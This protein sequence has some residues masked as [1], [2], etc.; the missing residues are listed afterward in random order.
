M[1]D[2]SAQKFAETAEAK[3]AAIVE[4]S[5]D[6][7]IGKDLEGTVTSWNG[8]A[9]KIFGYTAG[10]MVGASILR[11]IPPDRA[12]E[13]ERLMRRLKKGE[14]I[15]HFET[16]R[17]AKDGRLLDV[18]VAISPIIHAN[19]EIVG[20]SKVA[21]DITE[22][23]RAEADR[24]VLSKLESTGILAGGIAHDF[25]NL[26]TTILL[27]LELVLA[28]HLTADETKECLEMAMQSVMTS[29]GLTEQLITFADG[30]APNQQV[31]ALPGLIGKTVRLA[32]SGTRTESE[33]NLPGDLWSAD[34]DPGQ[35]GQVIQNL[36]LNAREAMS[37]A[38]VVSIRAEN[39]GGKSGAEHSLPPGNYIRLFITD[40]GAGIPKEILPTIFDPYVSTKQRGNR[41]GMGLGLTICHSIIQRHGGAITVE[42][43][44]GRG[45]TFKIHLPASSRPAPHNKKSPPKDP[46]R[47]GRLL[48]MDDD[49]GVRL[50]V[51]A[52]LRS[53]CHKVEMCADGAQAVTA[54]ENARALKQPF[55]AVI[56]DLTVRGG[57]GGL[58]ALQTLRGI[59]PAV[60]AIVISGHANDP[61]MLN[62]EQHGFKAALT[63]PFNR[64][65][66]AETIARIVKS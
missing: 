65:E 51:G 15:E 34:V 27:N 37:D 62:H 59:Y 21:R 22:R 41:K 42:S 7:I 63:K 1:L 6:D 17:L 3:L 49:D 61:V 64:E 14:N 31:T 46:P 9:E 2:I 10:E 18:S 11:L 32:L 12:H 23:K 48:V 29:R 53:A 16:V 58:E 54:F 55:D 50:S 47:P 45:T 24:L 38:G 43:N 13:E 5:S 35:I 56:L 33:L 4:S 66:L 57:M 39:V 44:V 19:G 20:F 40:Q 52:L 30:G 60:K 28:H 26:L 8:G 25:N 36:V